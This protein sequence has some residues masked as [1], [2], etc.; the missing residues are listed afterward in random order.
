MLPHAVSSKSN[1]QPLEIS[2]LRLKDA[3]DHQEAKPNEERFETRAE[4]TRS[5][6]PLPRASVQGLPSATVMATSGACQ[7]QGTAGGPPL[8]ARQ[9]FKAA[10]PTCCAASVL[11]G[12]RAEGTQGLGFRAPPET[13]ST[14]TCTFHGF[15]L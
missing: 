13:S 5:A 1:P 12:L 2:S 15:S 6:T 14:R 3:N 9:R 4:I 11:F 7:A 10:G 8:G